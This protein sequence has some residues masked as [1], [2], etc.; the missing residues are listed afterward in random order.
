MN[1]PL[2]PRVDWRSVGAGGLVTLGVFLGAQVVLRVIDAFHHLGQRSN[3]P[4]LFVPVVIFGWALGA[5]IAARRQPLTPL[6]HGALAAMAGYLVGAVPIAIGE[7]IA[8]TEF[9]STFE[10]IRNLVAFVILAGVVGT[11]TGWWFGF[12]QSRR[13]T[14]G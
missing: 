7:L 12:R 3:V 1:T 6:T 4:A 11:F 2:V 10:V 14:A 13:R 8:G 5:W 9:S